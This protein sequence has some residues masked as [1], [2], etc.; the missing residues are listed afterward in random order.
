MIWS[1]AASLLPAGAWGVFV[2]GPSAFAVMAVSVGSALIS[3]LLTGLLARRFTL[4]DGSAF[5]T[6]LLVGCLMPP[7]VPLFVPAAASVFAILVV[8]ESFGGLGKNWM[9]PAIAG[10]VFVLFSWRQAMGRFAAPGLFPVAHAGA[11]TPL[12]S[13]LA[14]LA[15][16]SGPRGDPFEIL[17]AQGYPFSS[18]DSSVVEWLNAHLLGPFGISA[19]R[20][21]VDLLLGN[22]AGPIGE[23]SPLLLLAG[24]VFLLARRVIRWEIPAAYLITFVALTWTLGGI[25]SGQGLFSGDILFHL[26]AGGIILGAFFMASDPVTSPLS[27]RAR[28]TYAACLGALTFLLRFYGSLAEGVSLAIIVMNCGVPL[29]DSLFRPGA[30]IRAAGGG[31]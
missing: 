13:V 5:L 26:L 6:G 29:L 25:S 1:V 17:R 23:I 14:A 19:P 20:G 2:F 12:A 16:P 10:R 9:N 21:C 11:S 30:A 3:E 31:A 15:D 18:I 8:K 4:L 22:V 28:M 24:A 27:F 7:G